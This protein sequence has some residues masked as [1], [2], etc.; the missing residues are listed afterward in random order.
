MVVDAV[1][2]FFTDLVSALAS[3]VPD[4]VVVF[5][6]FVVVF[7]VL[8]AFAVVVTFVALVTFAVVVAIFGAVAFGAFTAFGDETFTGA[9]P[10][11]FEAAA[12]GVSIRHRTIAV[13]TEIPGMRMDLTSLHGVQRNCPFIL[14]A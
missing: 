10:F 13:P 11:P 4:V 6:V 3:F 8:E 9:C 2:D 1:L 12:S 7:G 14:A 5:V